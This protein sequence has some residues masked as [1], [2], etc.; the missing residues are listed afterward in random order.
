MSLPPTPVACSSGHL[1]LWKS[2][3]SEQR[4]RV[5]TN[6]AREILELLGPPGEEALPGDDAPEEGNSV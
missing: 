1:L 3:A 4:S 5:I 2:A 6:D